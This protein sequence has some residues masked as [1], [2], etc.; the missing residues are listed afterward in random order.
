[1]QRVTSRVESS[2]QPRSTPAIT[3]TRDAERAVRF[4]SASPWM[5]RAVLHVCPSPLRHH[6]HPTDAPSVF[7]RHTSRWPLGG[8]QS[9]SSR[10]CRRHPSPQCEAESDSAG[11]TYEEQQTFG[12]ALNS[13]LECTPGRDA[14]SRVP[15]ERCRQP[16][17][18]LDLFAPGPMNK[19]S[20]L[21]AARRASSSGSI[22]FLCQPLALCSAGRVAPSF[23]GRLHR[24]RHNKRTYRLP[25]STLARLTC[26]I[27]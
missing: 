7:T 3:H 23:A 11:N 17:A 19:Q 4:C 8:G 20:T 21:K 27:A 5:L 16:L 14:C 2:P 6:N 1:M 25:D 9:T 15:C 18:T 26:V 22:C 24:H 12:S 13:Q 10:A